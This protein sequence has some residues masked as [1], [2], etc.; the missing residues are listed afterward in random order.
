MKTNA[1]NIEN[2]YINNYNVKNEI[3]IKHV[4]K[5]NIKM[6]GFGF[7]RQTRHRGLR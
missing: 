3:L 2:R 4:V 1:I 5:T 6:L 7:R